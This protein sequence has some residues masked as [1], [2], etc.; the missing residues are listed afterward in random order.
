MVWLKKVLVVGGGIVGWLVVCYLVKVMCLS[1][2]LVVQVYLVEVENIGLLGVGEVM[3][4]LICG[5]LVVIGLDECC[6]FDGVYVIYKQG[7]YY[8]YWV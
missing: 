8:C 5:M 7:I 1:D 2:L 3:F 6:F 4:F